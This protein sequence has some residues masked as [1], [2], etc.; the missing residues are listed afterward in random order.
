MTSQIIFLFLNKNF[1]FINNYLNNFSENVC[2]LELKKPSYLY[3][4]INYSNIFVYIIHSTRLLSK[5]FNTLVYFHKHLIQT[6]KSTFK[7][8]E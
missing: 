3:V 7:I 1:F 2:V 6:K 5:F 8:F 4:L